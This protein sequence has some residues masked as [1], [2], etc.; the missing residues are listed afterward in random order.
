MLLS[1]LREGLT[2]LDKRLMRDVSDLL[3]LNVGDEKIVRIMM[4]RGF[5][6]EQ[7]KRVIKD[8]RS[9]SGTKHEPVA[10]H[11]SAPVTETIENSPSKRFGILGKL[12]GKQSDEEMIA[13]ETAKLVKQEQHLKNE[14]ARVHAEVQQLV[15][16]AKSLEGQEPK[17]ARSPAGI[18]D[19]VK[20]VLHIVDGLL[21]KLPDTEIER[22]TQSPQFERYKAVMKKYLG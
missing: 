17:H 5:T 20:D 9:K 7:V 21:E 22:F 10:H 18:P 8:I 3:E 14:E 16:K 11:K 19:D 6:T 4:V 15:Q 12:F 1:I 13:E 2:M